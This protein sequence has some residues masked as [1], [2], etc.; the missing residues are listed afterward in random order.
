MKKVSTI[1]ILLLFIFVSI[2]PAYA[3]I[4]DVPKVDN[5]VK[6]YDFAELFNESQELNLRSGLKNFL[7]DN[8]LD[9]VIVTTNENSQTAMEYADDFYDYND[10]GVG[11]SKDGLLMLIDM[12]NRTI[13]ISTTGKA[14][15]IYKDK[16]IDAILDEVFASLGTDENFYEASKTFIKASQQKYDAYTNQSSPLHKVRFFLIG[17][18]FNPPAYVITM[19]IVTILVSVEKRKSKKLVK[20]A[21]NYFSASDVKVLDKKDTYIRTTTTRRTIERSNSNSSGGSSTHRSS[22][23]RTHGGGGRKF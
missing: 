18:V 19:I 3:G 9:I 11:G 4:D 14:I 15:K 20:T 22:S 1:I 8:N 12:S 21:I 7:D 17:L 16:D 6:V 13:W 5:T 23:G 2:V 10:F